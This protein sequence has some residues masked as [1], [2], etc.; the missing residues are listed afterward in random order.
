MS[1]TC[2]TTDELC[3]HIKYVS[4]TI[5]EQL[6]DS[7]FL[8][9][10]TEGLSLRSFTTSPFGIL[11]AFMHDEARPMSIGWISAGTGSCLTVAN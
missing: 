8:E 10:M 3:E 6:K 11:A 9:G 5:R 2:L 7:V 1:L 4:R